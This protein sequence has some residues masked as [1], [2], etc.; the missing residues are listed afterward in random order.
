MRA[1]FI[2]TTSSTRTYFIRLSP[3]H[4]ETATMKLYIDTHS[5][6]SIERP[7]LFS[8]SLSTR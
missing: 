6:G 3:S 8:L 1:Q 5:R 2:L 7:E 4:L